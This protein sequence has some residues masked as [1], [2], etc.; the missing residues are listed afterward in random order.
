MTT[1]FINLFNA[2]GNVKLS[3]KFMVFWT[4]FTWISIPLGIKL[5]GYN[6]ISVAFFLQ[7]LTFIF[8]YIQ[9]KKYVDISL[10]EILKP[11][12]SA[13]IVMSGWLI[14]VFIM[15]QKGIFGPHIHLALSILTAPMIYF[16]VL[17]VLKGKSIIQEG[18]E[19]IGLSKS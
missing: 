16:A 9:A 2:V 7:S 12:L 6:G 13:T 14:L 19:L 4:V 18:K 5:L 15:L 17:Y 11:A 10:F 3:L 1:P 8:V